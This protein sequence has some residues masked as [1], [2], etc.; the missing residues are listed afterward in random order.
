MIYVTYFTKERD[1]N[2][3]ERQ[4]Q[5]EKY[6]DPNTSGN[7]GRPIRYDDGTSRSFCSHE[8]GVRIPVVVSRSEGQTII[9]LEVRHGSQHMRWTLRGKEGPTNRFT[10]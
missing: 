3:V 6:G 10:K 1:R 2:Y 5:C 8:D 4:N 7:V 9:G